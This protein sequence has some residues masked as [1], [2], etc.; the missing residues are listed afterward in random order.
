MAANK[1]SGWGWV[2]VLVLAAGCAAPTVTPALTATPTPR[3]PASPTASTTLIEVNATATE[4]GPALTPSPTPTELG[5]AATR[6]LATLTPVGTEPTPTPTRPRLTP[7]ATLSATQTTTVTATSSA[8]VTTTALTA[9]PT[10]TGTEAAPLAAR[11][12][13]SNAVSVTQ[14]AA[15]GPA[16][17]GRVT[18]AGTVTAAAT[19]TATGTVTPVEGVRLDQVV[20]VPVARGAAAQVAV[21]GAVG[22]QVYDRATGQLIQQ[23]DTSAWATSLAFSLEG[24]ALAAGTVN[25]SVEV[26]DARSGELGTLLTGPGIRVAQVRY[27]PVPGSVLP[28]GYAVA[29]LGVNNV[30]HFWDV[31]LQTY[32]GPLDPGPSAVHSLDLSPRAP[33]GRQWLALAVGQTARVWNL[34]ALVAAAPAFDAA[35]SAFDLA[36]PAALTALALSP[37]GRWLAAASTAGSIRLWNLTA[38]PPTPAQTLAR[39]AA[40]AER[41]VFSPD[42]SVLASAH[43]DRVI[44]LWAVAGGAAALVELTGHTE[45][46]TS[47]AFSAD[48]R[49]LASTGWEGLVRV[50]GVP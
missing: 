46:V 40:P 14:L 50:W 44:R 34:P 15:F 47:L 36:Q 4:L 6:V 17:A 22:V 11:I 9:T 30:L 3:L 37:D 2:A 19:V 7:T 1:R 29:S 20:W 27:V 48:G 32:L 13:V 45:R 35:P 23:I 41:L 21:A 25:A 38:D 39:L 43:G 49:E 42:S 5:Q 16:L 8:P 28:A 31:A 12:T 18:P 10:L 33:A 26:Y 24:R